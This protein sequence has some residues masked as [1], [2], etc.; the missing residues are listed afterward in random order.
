MERQ[1]RVVKRRIGAYPSQWAAWQQQADREGVRSVSALI[2]RV[3]T[4][5]VSKARQRKR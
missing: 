5:Y 4:G 1:E 3:L 2:R